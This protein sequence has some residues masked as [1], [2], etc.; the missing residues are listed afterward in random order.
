MRGAAGTVLL[1]LGTTALNFAVALVL[2]RLLG[3]DGYG[4]FAF[5]F[6]WATVLS[7][8]A[9]LGLSPL[10]VRHVAAMTAREDW[11]RLRGLL[12][13]A[14]TVVTAASLLAIAVAAG[15][16]WYLLDEQILRRPTLI[17]LALVLPTALVIIRQSAMQGLGRVVLGRV[18]ETIV[19]PGL[20]LALAAAAGSTSR[21][22]A[23][24]AVGLLLAA[25]LAA[26]TLGAVLLARALPAAVRAAAPHYDRHSWARSATPLFLLGLVG[27]VG[28]QA[29]T[30]LMGV[31]AAPRDTGVFALA[32]RVSTFAG[33]LFL[34]ATYPLMPAVARLHST[35]RAEE[36]RE[37]IQRAA[38]IVFLLSLPVAAAI[39]ALAGPLLGVF[40]DEFRSG[41]VAVC[42][43]VL[44]ELVKVFLGLSGLA[45]VMTGHEDDFARG[46]VAG[47]AVSVVL[48]V[49]LIPPLDTVGA[50][51][52]TAGGVVVTHLLLTVLARRR[53]GFAG[54]A[55]W[56]QAGARSRRS[57][58]S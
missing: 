31:F 32:L 18:P 48:S 42:L 26:L 13:W 55:W 14:N 12:R 33:F 44:G 11:S 28:S 53:L 17:G 40:G 35:G 37:T 19:A 50:A 10:I 39:A 34:A 2:A 6:A 7:S 38:R 54:A 51:L 16:A 5:A 8:L 49:V 15:C 57:I 41:D 46:V 27:V 24:L 29:S 45:L 23:S 22:S 1:N 4:A 47:A 20:F 43:L 9:G 58:Q 56:G 21:L 52:A 36:L 30:I 3:S 25:T